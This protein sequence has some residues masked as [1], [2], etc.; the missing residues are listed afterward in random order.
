MGEGIVSLKETIVVDMKSAMRAKDKLK[1]STIR[2]LLA[3]IKQIE[4][5]E[6][7]MLSD[8]GISTLVIKMIKQRQDSIAQFSDANRYDLADKENQEMGILKSYVLDPLS[9]DEIDQIIH[10]VFAELTPTGLQDMG[11]IMSAVKP[12]VEGR[13]DM[14]SISQQVKLRLQQG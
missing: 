3:A 2:L 5:D 12:Q 9:T 10:A 1:L 13:A 14:G 8:V 6:K 11:R 4:I 7:I